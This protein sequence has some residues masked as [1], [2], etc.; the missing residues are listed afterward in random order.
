[1]SADRNASAI[2]VAKSFDI[3][4]EFPILTISIKL[5]FANLRS[6]ASECNKKELSLIKNYYLKNERVDIITLSSF[7]I[8][9]DLKINDYSKLNVQIN[10]PSDYPK[11]CLF[12]SLKS[13]TISSGV[14]D[15]IDQLVKIHADK[16]KLNFQV[17][18]VID[19]I[20]NFI[21]KNSFL[22]A[23]D[24]I[25]NIKDKFIFTESLH[26]VKLKQKKKSLIFILCYKKYKAH[27]TITI[28]NNYPN[29]SIAF[30]W[31]NDP[32]PSTI[33]NTVYK[34]HTKELAR[35]SVDPPLNK[36]KEK[37]LPEIHLYKCVNFIYQD[38]LVFF[39]DSVCPIC[40]QNI[41]PKDNDKPEDQLPKI[42]RSYCGHLFHF[43]CLDNFMKSPPFNAKKKCPLC[44]QVIFNESWNI[45]EFVVE[46]RWVHYQAHQ[47]E[48]SDIQDFLK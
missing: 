31:N 27:F 9:I 40:E 41:L 30:D 45:D 18:Q 19:L 35:S 20:L 33:L 24:E 8:V 15:K 28:P 32:F 7:Y 23:A 3:F 26:T 48:L 4:I 2:S 29:E 21:L 43:E 46:Q 17:Q 5:C 34:T 11:S 47:R 38:I 12:C 13:K 25:K 22:V 36:N 1:M 44:C 10:F 6:M 14:L 39:V 37:K 16:Y 42:E